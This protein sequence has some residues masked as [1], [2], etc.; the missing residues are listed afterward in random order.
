MILRCLDCGNAVAVVPGGFPANIPSLRG[1]VC[2]C[3]HPAEPGEKA[4]PDEANTASKRQLIEGLE[5]AESILG[6]MER[7]DLPNDR[8][9]D[10]YDRR[11][12]AARKAFMQ[13][14]RPATMA[15]HVGWLKE[16]LSKGGSVRVHRY[17]LPMDTYFVLLKNAHLPPLHGAGSVNVMVP[18]G[19]K[20]H[21]DKDAHSHNDVIEEKHLGEGSSMATYPDVIQALREE[22]DET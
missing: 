1:E 19:L 20:I 12:E 7:P 22:V 2:D 6:A 5:M 16:H 15:D 10:I 21:F 14:T 11:V 8:I 17:S 18:D 13:S 4:D 3:D 9:N